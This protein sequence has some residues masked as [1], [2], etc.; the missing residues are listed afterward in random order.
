MARVVLVTGATGKQGGALVQALLRQA[1]NAF[2]I[3]ALTRNTTSPSAQKLVANSS[4]VS[5]V[6][7]DLNETEAIFAGLKKD[8]H[9]VWGVFGV[10]VSDI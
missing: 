6:Q 4:N 9:S 8:G 7:G 5:L 10:Q 1:P 3:M 2:R